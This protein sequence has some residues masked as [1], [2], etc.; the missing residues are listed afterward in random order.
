MADAIST[1]EAMVMR[2]L[3]FWRGK[4]VFVTGHTGF[5]GAWLCRVLQRAGAV[6]TGYS[7]P[8]PTE[9]SLFNLADISAKTNTVIG[10]ILDFD[11]LFAAFS[12]AAPEIVFHLAAQPIVR[13]GYRTPKDTYAV[14]VM[15]TVHLLECVRRTLSVQSSRV[16]PN[17]TTT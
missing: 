3:S 8:P 9:P 17:W 7:L 1:L 14:N 11:R 10:D 4:R 13:E 15:G 6:V 5:K 2:M 16:L 12:T